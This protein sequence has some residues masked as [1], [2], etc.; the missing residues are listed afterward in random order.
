[1]SNI[2]IIDTNDVSFHDSNMQR[3]QFT[4]E[5][6]E[7][8]LEDYISFKPVKDDSDLLSLIIKDVADENN[9]YDIHTGIV[10]HILDELYLICH[11]RPSKELYDEFKTQGQKYNGIASYLTD[12]NLRIYKKAILIKLDTI[13]NTNKI[14][15]ITMNNIINVF[16]KKFLH[17]G[18][19]VSGDGNFNELT[20]IFNPLDNLMGPSAFNYKYYEVEILGKT[21]MIF[22]DTSSQTKNEILG[23]LCDYPLFGN[24]IIALHNQIQDVQNPVL[25]YDDIVPKELEKI[26]SLFNENKSH[27]LKLT[28]DENLGYEVQDNKRIYNNFHKIL[29]MR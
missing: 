14:G 29:R 22:H 19:L 5:S 1:M 17:K 3:S 4:Y 7:D 18:V 12:E 21:L 27:E 25:I 10:S 2:A 16:T 23:K 20:Y 26:I 28:A 11:I 8:R 24:C 15:T 6:L 13:N 9:K